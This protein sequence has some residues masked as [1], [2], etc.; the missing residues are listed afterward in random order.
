MKAQNFHTNSSGAFSPQHSV[1][2]VPRKDEEMVKTINN[3]SSIIKSF[4]KIVKHSINDGRNVEIKD[5]DTLP[6]TSVHEII[7]TMQTSIDSIDLSLN[8]FIIDAKDI[9]LRL[10][11]MRK[12]LTIRTN[13]NVRATVLNNLQPWSPSSTRM[14]SNSSSPKKNKNN[15][16]L[17]V[18]NTKSSICLSEESLDL[19]KEVI[20]FLKEINPIEAKMFNKNWE[21]SEKKKKFANMID[22]LYK[23]IEK[24]LSINNANIL[25]NKG[26]INSVRL[27]SPMTVNHNYN[28]NTININKSAKKKSISLSR[29]K[30][31]SNKELR[32]LI[33]IKE[34][35][36]EKMTND[37]K[38]KNDTIHKTNVLVCNLKDN[39][40]QLNKSIMNYEE[41]IRELKAMNNFGSNDYQ[42]MKN[43][44]IQSEIDELKVK[45]K[46][47]MKD[48]DE[49][50]KCNEDYEVKFK[51]MKVEMSLD[52]ED[53]KQTI[54][55]LEHDLSEKTSEVLILQK[56]KE[57]LIKQ[58]ETLQTT[59][60]SAS[61]NEKEINELKN[62][63]EQLKK[64]NSDIRD[65]NKETQI[66]LNEALTLIS[67]NEEKIKI[68]N[69][70][71]KLKNSINEEL[72][73]G[74]NA[75]TNEI[76]NLTD[77]IN[78]LNTELFHAES[79][80]KSKNIPMPKEE[81][82]KNKKKQNDES[83]QDKLMQTYM[84]NI[85]ILKN[86]NEKFAK[87]FARI[88]NELTVK[89]NNYNMLSSQY[90]K[91]KN[92]YEKEIKT[93]DNTMNDMKETL[94]HKSQMLATQA[95]EILNFTN[96]L[97]EKDSKL[98][99]V[100]SA[101][102][103]KEIALTEL[104]KQ[105][106]NLSAHNENLQMKYEIL[107]ESQHKLSEEN[108]QLKKENFRY[109]EQLKNMNNSSIMKQNEEIIEKMKKEIKFIKID[110]DSLPSGST[111]NKS[112][113]SG[114]YSNESNF[115]KKKSN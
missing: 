21:I 80:L 46:E 88:K 55:K 98:Q 10:K 24:I 69:E 75:K 112:V 108:E 51:Q 61:K 50:V 62:L 12:N 79:E 70:E 4:Y 48:Y 68:L 73:N 100:E 11:T 25:N 99:T 35:T 85:V 6:I 13:R 65:N 71:I 14:L 81:E 86:E 72:A 97:K 38:I 77:K 33:K 82:K 106:A 66:K 64:E 45:N 60:I 1:Q 101:L 31:D 7:S 90:I 104:T 57:N 76:K 89:T 16:T 96:I 113:L 74:M 32:S 3:L 91:D 115:G 49:L 54:Q 34:A 5:I 9:F 105:N 59:N 41:K 47:L 30:Q 27:S 23:V 18:N 36:I 94:K 102:K 2:N 109:L 28:F 8:K 22:N 53:K 37:I 19:I 92:Y 17:D 84:N 111:K 39:I 67:S 114:E 103:A 43:K 56:E 26:T 42:K 63:N 93:K 15:S 20:T 107:S 29:T 78:Q 87:E 40:K 52:M 44:Q 58:I 95:N 110:G 83:A